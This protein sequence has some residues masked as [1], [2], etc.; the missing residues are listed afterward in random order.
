MKAQADTI[1][2]SQKEIVQRVRQETGSGGEATIVDNRPTRVIQQKLKSAMSEPKKP[3]QLKPSGATKF[4]KIAFQMGNQYGVDTS[5]LK[6]THNSSFPAKLNA[7][8]TIQGNNIHFAP[9]MDT[10]YNMRHEV[11]HAIDNT[12]H[13]TPKGNRVV[14]GKKV[15]TTREK[16]VDRMAKGSKTQL[17]T[18]KNAGLTKRVDMFGGGI[19][20]QEISKPQ[21]KEK[22]DPV[23][24]SLESPN[25]SVY[26]LHVYEKKS[27]FFKR[28]ERRIESYDRLVDLLDIELDNVSDHW[29]RDIAATLW[30]KFNA[31]TSD[32]ITLKDIKNEISLQKKGAKEAFSFF[33]KG[34]YFKSGNRKNERLKNQENYDNRDV[35]EYGWLDEAG[36]AIEEK[37]MG[38]KEDLR[39]DFYYNEQAEN[40]INN[41]NALVSRKILGQGG[42]THDNDKKLKNHDYVFG[43]LAHVNTP[44]TPKRYMFPNQAAI[45]RWKRHNDYDK[46]DFLN[47]VASGT[48]TGAAAGNPDLA[49]DY[50]L[51]QGGRRR[52]RDFM[53]HMSA[54]GTLLQAGDLLDEDKTEYKARIKKNT[55]PGK[56]VG[57]QEGRNR[58]KLKEY[59]EL[60]RAEGILKDLIEHI[61]I[62]W[63]QSLEHY[64]GN[65]ADYEKKDKIETDIVNLL[66]LDGEDFIAY[67]TKNVVRVQVLYPRRDYLAS[68]TIESIEEYYDFEEYNDYVQRGNIY[69]KM[70]KKDDTD[71]LQDDWEILTETSEK[72]DMNNFK[73]EIK[74][75]K[76]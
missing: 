13:G 1:Q 57:A 33:S 20:R 26:Q 67:L 73:E 35:K 6:A 53:S 28:N 7:E 10:D 71:E 70:V 68:H 31:S 25:N 62:K 16:V 5:A 24:K 34:F 8:A 69:K 54:P 18:K 51:M 76:G 52:R 75:Y 59:K 58:A 30:D 21:N 49:V 11:A 61:K 17:G 44:M 56:I 38:M 45:D 66:G 9:G 39:V 55:T 65:D 42:K 14:N 12:I 41:A 19:Q 40:A 60:T 64:K 50:S 2:E 43:Y 74:Q 63:W 29:R 23:K 47:M 27:F 37:L 3:I 22:N 46:K 32:H 48:I 72:E 15:D 36:K 4:Q